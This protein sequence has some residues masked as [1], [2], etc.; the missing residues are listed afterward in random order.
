MEE[1]N[2]TEVSDGE[3]I[4]YLV[5]SGF[6]KEEVQNAIK[7]TGSKDIDLLVNFIISSTQDKIHKGVKQT[8]KEYNNTMP[9]EAAELEKKRREEIMKERIYR[10]QLINQIK[11]DMAEKLERDKLEDERLMSSTVEKSEDTSDC[12]I[13]LWLGDGT[14]SILGFSKDDTIEDLFKKIE[15]RLNK[16]RFSLFKMNHVK[17][18]ERNTKKISEIPGLY[19]RG[20]LFIEE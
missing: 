19:P 18:I 5:Q 11:A 17:P 7:E 14:S 16:K 13:K 1:R 4:S 6:T 2:K 20:V 10:E 3:V 12:K 15:T 9:K 8:K